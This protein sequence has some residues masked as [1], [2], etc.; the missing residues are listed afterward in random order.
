ME[1]LRFVFLTS[2]AIRGMLGALALSLL[3]DCGS[4]PGGLDDAS[5]A[6][7]DNRDSGHPR[8]VSD[9]SDS[10][11]PDDASLAK[12]AAFQDG[13]SSTE[14]GTED[15]AVKWHPGHYMA[16]YQRTYAG[17]G[18]L[19]DKQAEQA[20]L[21]ASPPEAL[22]WEGI[23]IWQA[24][25]DTTAGRYDF[26]TLITDYNAVTGWNGTTHVS[27]RRFMIM[28]W[29][30]DFFDTDPTIRTLPTYLT[31]DS[32]YGPGF[33]G[34]HYGYWTLGTYGSTA[35]VWRPAVMARVEALFD[36]MASTALPDGFTFDTSPYVEAVMFQET[37]LSLAAGSDDSPSAEKAQ[38]QGLN[39]A[40]ATA[41]SH[42]NVACQAN[43]PGSNGNE[44]DMYDLVETF[45]VTR[46]A[47]SGPDLLPTFGSL[48]WG[49]W[50]YEGYQWNGSAFVTGGSDLRG[51]VAGIFNIQSDYG[52]SGTPA[53]IFAQ[54]DGELH[55]THLVWTAFTGA[56]N[57]ASNWYG[58]A[59]NVSVWTPANGGVLR[60]IVG[61]P[62]THV[63]CRSTYGALGGCNGT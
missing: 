16:S 39:T 37:A 28:V 46:T 36:A 10:R 8:S 40:M 53:E 26:S 7:A 2:P 51:V 38:W 21:A 18:K 15:P 11:V 59:S 49:Q 3:V 45:S 23:Y 34:T 44:S 54:G 27:P 57:Q 42:T 29:A 25:E 63:G 35:A 19:P 6:S 32:A 5:D 33:D 52:P 14:A 9:A 58:T 47:A 1:E 48:T 30:E 50:S 41:F 55:A 17:N 56:T 13:T 20:M 31:S 61:S 62:L 12:D 24:M 60:T 43:Y 22:G 4:R